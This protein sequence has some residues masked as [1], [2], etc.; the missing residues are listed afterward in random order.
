MFYTVAFDVV[1]IQ[2]CILVNV[3]H[4]KHRYLHARVRLGAW[5]SIKTEVHVSFQGITGAKQQDTQHDPKKVVLV[6]T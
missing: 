5:V 2:T 6:I 1:V 3:Q 4:F